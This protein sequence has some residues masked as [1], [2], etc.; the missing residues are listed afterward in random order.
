MTDLCC[1]PRHKLEQ[2]ELDFFP[3]DEVL[4]VCTVLKH[5]TLPWPVRGGELRHGTAAHA[6]AHSEETW[7]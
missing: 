2:L 7:V 5:D 6:G 1:H 4:F 3:Y